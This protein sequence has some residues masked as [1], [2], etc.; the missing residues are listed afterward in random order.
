M[1]DSSTGK[2]SAYGLDGHAEGPLPIEM[3]ALPLLITSDST[4]LTLT[5]VPVANPLTGETTTATSEF[6]ASSAQ[7]NGLI[8]FKGSIPNV[9]IKGQTLSNIDFRYPEGN[10]E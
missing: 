2:L 10:E 6:S 8:K 4:S 1:L 9:T 3:A 5:L 7:L